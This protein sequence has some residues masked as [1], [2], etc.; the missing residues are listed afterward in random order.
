MPD[1]SKPPK[2]GH[3]FLDIV[4]GVGGGCICLGDETG[5][6]R[7]AGPKPWGGGTITHRH[8]ISISDVESVIKEIQNRQ[9][10]IGNW[11]GDI[12]KEGADHA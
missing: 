5:G 11:P 8:E 12:N 7:I 6:R 2:A 10:R 3:I 4:S 1:F 9:A